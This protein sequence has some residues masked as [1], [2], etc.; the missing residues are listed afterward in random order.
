VNPYFIVV[1]EFML[2]QTTTQ[3]VVG[4][5]ERFIRKYPTIQD[6]A[7]ADLNDVMVLWQGLGYYSRAERLHRIAINCADIGIPKTFDELIQIKGIGPYM[8]G[9]ISSMA[10][11]QSMISLDGN[12]K[13]ILSRVMREDTQ[14]LK[15]FAMT[16]KK[17]G[18]INQALMDI[19]STICKPN[20]PQC[21]QC[22]LSHRCK[23]HI[24][25]LTQ[26]FP[27]KR[28]KPKRENRF[29][30]M[31]VVVQDQHVYVQKRQKGI[32]ANLYTLPLSEFQNQPDSFDII[33]D[34]THFRL[35]VQLVQTD[36]NQIKFCNLQDQTLLKAIPLNQLHVYPL[37]RL[38]QK[39]INML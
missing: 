9:A 36:I 22:P 28:I 16:T 10:Y 8:A 11:G 38:T 26:D 21:D 13:R 34:F 32:W 4:Y 35:H 27:I 7:K 23:S 24:K 1:S 2:Q 19:G 33:H 31:F 17:P 15:P 6:L 29:C 39:I 5:F 25:N 14:N 37:S 30:R 18:L 12:L 3:V 20:A